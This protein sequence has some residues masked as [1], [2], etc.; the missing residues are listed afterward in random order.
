[1]AILMLEPTERLYAYKW[2]EGRVASLFG[3]SKPKATQDGYQVNHVSK[4]VSF[5]LHQ[6]IDSG[7][8]TLAICVSNPKTDDCHYLTSSCSAHCDPEELA[9][10]LRSMARQLVRLP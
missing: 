7:V 1:M 4:V 3:R 2:L 5:R 6:E 8:C 10:A 9:E